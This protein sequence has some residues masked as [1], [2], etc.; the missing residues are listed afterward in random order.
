M[1]GGRGERGERYHSV[2]AL[3]SSTGTWTGIFISILT[4]VIVGTGGAS[5]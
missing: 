4:Y 5:D 2:S 1:R 3:G